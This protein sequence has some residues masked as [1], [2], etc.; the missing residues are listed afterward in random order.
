MSLRLLVRRKATSGVDIM[1]VHRWEEVRILPCFFMMDDK[2]RRAGSN[3]ITRG[4]RLACP[5]YCH[6]V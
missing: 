3:V 1:L 2:G 4:T 6:W 5:W